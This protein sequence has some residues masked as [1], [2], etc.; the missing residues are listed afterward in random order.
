MSVDAS[1]PE[2]K[3]KRGEGTLDDDM[4]AL[5]SLACRCRAQKTPA[6]PPVAFT[7]Q[8]AEADLAWVAMQADERQES[9]D[10]TSDLLRDTS[11]DA[12]AALLEQ[13]GYRLLH[14]LADSV[15]GQVFLAESLRA[16][17]GE[18][19]VRVAIKRVNKTLCEQK[20]TFEDED[21]MNEFVDEDVLKEAFILE[22]LTVRNKATGDHVAK[23]VELL[24]SEQHY[25]LITEYVDGI[26]VGELADKAHALILAGKLSRKS[27]LKTVKF[28][29]WQ[30]TGALHW[31]QGVY[32]CCH[33]DICVDNVMIENAEFEQQRDGSYVASQRLKVRLIDFGV[34][35]LFSGGSF[36]CFKDRLSVEHG[37]YVAPEVFCNQVYDARKADAWSLGMILYRLVTNAAPFLA[38]DIWDEAQNGYAALKAGR[39]GK[40]MRMNNLMPLFGKN[41]AALLES[42]LQFDQ[43]RRPLAGQAMRAKWFKSYWQRY[44]ALI[45][46]QMARDA[47]RL[48]R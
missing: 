45:A 29:M 8:E 28:I 13:Q 26:T 4:L 9:E 37:A 48:T 43:D 7:Q 24:E 25:F 16:S 32:G 47:A 2:R 11:F 35:E 39:L 20:M 31:L 12:D 42:L 30:L 46:Q 21:G 14:K 22:H 44:G 33:L 23:F 34:A 27:W 19:A 41:A 5:E 17:E 6:T 38:E 36:A 40:W 3:R 10:E 1:I 15:Q 18:A